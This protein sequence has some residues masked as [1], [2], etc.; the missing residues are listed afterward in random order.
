MIAQ[1]HRSFLDAGCDVVETNTFGAN[2]LVLGEFDLAERAYEL[3]VKAAKI[4]REA[5]DGVA[6]PNHPRYVAGSIG[7]GTKLISLRQTTYDTLGESYLE[8]MRG[9]VDGGV[10]ALVIET[11][12]DILQTKV[13]I[14]AARRAFEACGRSVPLICQVTMET[15][16]TMLMGTE[17]AAAAT[18]LEAFPEVSV[19]GLNCA[20]GPREMSEHVR[21]LAR[22]CTRPISVQPNA[23]L[24]EVADGRARFPLT[25][26]ELARWLR[27]FVEEEGVGVVGGCCGTTPDHI[28]AV[29][30]A[31]RGLRPKQRTPAP[32]PAVTSLYQATALRQDTS[33]L[34]VGERCNTNGSR[35]F[36]RLLAE[37][38]IEGMV[39]MARE[40]MHEGAHVLDVCV[41]Y[42]G[43]DGVADMALVIDRFAGDLPIPLML[44]STEP[45]VIEAGLKLA[46]G[47]CI[48]NSVNLEDGE[49]KIQEVCRLLRQHGAAV[50]ALTIDEHPEEAMAKTAERKL[51]IAERIHGLL[52][53][54][55]GIAEENIF[56]DCLTFPITT[57]SASDRR[58]ALE[59]LDGIERVA[60]RFPKCQ[61]ILGVSN[62][63]FGLQPVARVVLNSAFL[64]E[65][66]QRGLTAAIMHAGKILPRTQISDE[67]W[68]TAIDLIYNRREK[69]DPLER[70]I[71][72]FSEGEKVAV[73]ADVADLPLDE[74]LRQRIIDGNK[75][76]LEAD[77]NEALKTHSPIEIINDYLLEGMKTVGELFASGK[78]QLPFVLKSAE[79]MKAAVT[80][81]EPYMDKVAG[82]SRGKI[83]LATVRGDV[84]DIGKNL[85]DIILSNNGLHGVQPRHQAADRQR[86]QCA[87]RAQ[88]RCDRPQRPAGQVDAGDARGSTGA[89]RAGHR[90]PG[91]PRRGGAEP[92][93]R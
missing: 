53:E 25:P 11:C 17:M 4:A 41:D 66:L 84:H 64:H 15:T 42:V 6:T 37:G 7:P 47:K 5:C 22:H 93:L 87:A 31:V 40:Q 12:Q 8:Q 20:T 88:R 89:Q 67:R 76:G 51:H 14:H 39:E 35:K 52:T 79:T 44:D 92:A 62:V 46:G 43:R 61:L 73:A 18:I 65:A 23:G 86:D 54:K 29:A 91:H 16:G 38:D 77:L 13:A 30:E 45:Q 58:L 71:G 34:I 78:M 24:P 70:F 68:E 63:S 9:L 75:R 26:E 69:G 80:H 48:V 82:T 2:R 27:E 3:N 19:I 33:F 32:E 55:Y 21:Y 56:F 81:L 90:G 36:K 49:R 50:V 74:R 60:R 83:V 85:A 10:D 28:R 1:I 72:L 59:T 57:G